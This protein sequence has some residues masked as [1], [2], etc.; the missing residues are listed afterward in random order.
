MGG[1]IES[2][3]GV[4]S[5]VAVGSRAGPIQPF[6]THIESLQ[7]VFGIINVSR[8][9]VARHFCTFLSGFRFPGSEEVL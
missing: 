6:D 4:E 1:T 9:M 8:K 2:R 3:G 5:R 7:R